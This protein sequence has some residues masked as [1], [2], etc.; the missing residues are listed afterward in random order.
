MTRPPF[1]YYGGKQMLADRIL[2]LLPP[3][4]HYVEPY[5]GSL[6]LLLA[7]PRTA[8]ETVN[9]LDGNLVNFWR[10]LRERSDEL[11]EACGLTP[12]A[13][14]E[15]AEAMDL[16]AY[17]TDDP[18]ERARRTWVLLTQGQSGGTGRRTGWRFFVNPSGSV[19]SMPKYLE[20]YVERF[21]PAVARL[22]GVSIECRPA[23]DVITTY[24]R[25]P[26]VLLYVDPPYVHS[27]RKGRG[28]RHEMTDDDHRALAVV[29]REAKATVVL[30]GYP[31]GMY[32]LELYPDWHRVQ[33]ATGTGNGG[34]W[35]DRTEVLWSNVPL[36]VQG[37]LF[38]DMAGLAA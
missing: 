25:C 21:G 17:P 36:G 19:F 3:H 20:A 30:S 27:T 5:A 4:E 28:Y 6:A 22:F 16:E 11:E 32:D 33:L 14:A 35:R 18:V 10:V 26:G 8:F 15:H 38:A 34:E 31:S 23:L 12:H 24:G 9:D 13:R 2:P 1:P 29:L 37:D 7:K